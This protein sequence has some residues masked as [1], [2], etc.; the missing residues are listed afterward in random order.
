MIDFLRRLLN[1]GSTAQPRRLLNQGSTAQPLATG[2][3][4]LDSAAPNSQNL[5]PANAQSI[6][7][8]VH[9]EQRL[10]PG[11]R[12][13]QHILLVDEDRRFNREVATI[14]E[15][16]RSATRSLWFDQGL[17]IAIAAFAGGTAQWYYSS[18]FVKDQYSFQVSL[19][20]ILLLFI[21][22]T[23]TISNICEIRRRRVASRMQLRLRDVE[24]RHQQRMDQVLPLR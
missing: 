1:Q 4:L 18:V 2:N 16:T 7:S 5:V 23:V 10:V 24:E 21:I 20:V 8:S 3:F 12:A 13:D 22:I 15:G 6:V 9:P 14:E 11:I 19:L 17:W